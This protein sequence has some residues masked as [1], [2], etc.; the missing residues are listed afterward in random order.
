MF[1][2]QVKV[3]ERKSTFIELI[4]IKA[5]MPNL[6]RNKYVSIQF[7]PQNTR[8]FHSL[9]KNG[10]NQS[11][12]NGHQSAFSRTDVFC[13]SKVTYIRYMETTDNYLIGKK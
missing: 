5:E 10:R 9:T 12:R 8:P 1:T 7:F 2:S 4:N 13:T 11:I 6:E 3:Q